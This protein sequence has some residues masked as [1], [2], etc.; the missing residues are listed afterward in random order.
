ML[1]QQTLSTLRHL[2]LL[3]MADA[4]QQQLEQP[5]THDLA[6]AERFALLVDREATQRD[7]R[8][9]QRL[10][11]M[12]HLKQQACVE[13][14]DYQHRR[15]LDKSQMAALASCDWIRAHQQL[16]IT[17]PTGSGKSWLACALGHQAC[18]QGLSVRYERT[19]RLLEEL[20]IARGDGSLQKQFAAL[21]KT[22]LL[23]LDDFGLKPLA[24]LERLDLLDIIEDRYHMRSTLVTS[25]LPVENWHEYV[26]D[27]TVADALLDRLL[28]NAHRLEMKGESMR[29]K[30]DSLT[31]REHPE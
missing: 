16:H 6:F 2:K 22:D 8:R 21:A 25:Q 15:G 10:L 14:I 28:N 12:A 23:I 31:H 1:A 17:G 30:T 18:R 19:S 13:D 24:Q 9:L 3:G 20:R 4:Y 29:K 5:A 26:G 7:S 27:P 11:Q